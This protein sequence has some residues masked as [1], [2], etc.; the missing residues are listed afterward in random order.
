MFMFIDTVFTK[1]TPVNLI[2]MSD[3]EVVYYRVLFGGLH[4]DAGIYSTTQ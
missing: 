2:L 4:T 3:N 1:K